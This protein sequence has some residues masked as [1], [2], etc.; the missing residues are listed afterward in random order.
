MK[1]L[2]VEDDDWIAE[3]LAEALSDQS[4]VVEMAADGVIAWE[5]IQTFA[6]DLVIL[7]L[8]L[9][10]L[11]GISVCQYLRQAGYRMPVLMLTAKDTSLDKV[12]GL[13]VGA[14]DYVV[15][16]FDLKELLARVRALLRRGSNISS[17]VLTYGQLQVDPANCAVCY[18]HQPLKFTPK[19]YGLLEFFLRNPDRV[20]RPN[21]ILEHL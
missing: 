7:D 8:M 11:N 12:I 20:I 3:P 13:D 10:K 16:P 6:Y 4:Y 1:I 21:E 2:L 18:D 14:D 15:K 5:L 17:P 9:P 19:E